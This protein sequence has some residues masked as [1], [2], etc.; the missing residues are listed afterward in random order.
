MP[1]ASTPDLDHLV[2]CVDLIFGQTIE[3]CRGIGDE[4]ARLPTGCPGWSVQDQLAHMVGLEQMLSGSPNPT[5][6]LPD[7][8]HVKNDV[9]RLME[10][11]VHA[12]RPLPFAAVVDEMAGLW[13]RRI[14]QLREQA[15]RGDIE[16]AGLLG[17]TRRLS[18]ALP[19]RVMDLWSHEQDI[20]RAV[21]FAPRTDGPD[22]DLAESRTLGAWSV[23]LP[24][25]VEGPGQVE[26]RF[27][28]GRLSSATIALADGQE[29][30]AGEPHV[31]IS[32]TRSDLTQLGFGRQPLD[33]AP[34]EIDVDGDSRLWAR[35]RP[36]LTFTP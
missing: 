12:R 16:V 21:G 3:L 14:D 31:A 23:L 15:A 4:E 6:E 2:D 18:Q 34:I 5:V 32:G 13:P 20:R 9:G 28:D 30:P 24:K 25:N 1:D 33:S 26:I 17:G 11:H 27:A 29:G 22:G 10:L 36:H 19:I 7:F 8:D 35:V